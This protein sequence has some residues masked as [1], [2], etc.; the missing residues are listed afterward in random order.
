MSGTAET[1]EKLR[2]SSYQ[3]ARAKQAVYLRDRPN[4]CG[5]H[6]KKPAAFVSQQNSS[7]V[8]KRLQDLY[9]N[10]LVVGN[11]TTS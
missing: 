3:S 7:N 11:Q 5:H 1:G 4:N 8:F 10:Q 6:F 9:G 2:R